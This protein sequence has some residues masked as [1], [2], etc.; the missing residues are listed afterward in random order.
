MNKLLLAV[1]LALLSVAAGAQP[2]SLVLTGHVIDS[3]S[4]EK[5]TAATVVIRE[6]GQQAFTDDNGD[7]VFTRL[8]A[9]NYMIEVRH[10]GC[11]TLHQPVRLTANAHIDLALPHMRHNLAGV[12]VAAQTTPAIAGFSQQLAGRSLEETRGLSLAQALSRINGVSM[13]STGST[14]AKPV[15]HG[16]HSNRILT[17]NNGVRQ[18]G[19]QWGNEHA[20]EID[21]YLADKLTVIKGVDELKYGS[22]AIGGVIL[23]DPR[24]LRR[25]PGWAGEWNTGYFSNYR[26]YVV[27]GIIEQQLENNPALAWRIQGT[28]KQN[29]NVATPGYR[30]NNTALKEL[31]FSA[32]A[33]WRK[34]HYHIQAYFSQFSTDLGLFTGSHTTSVTDLKTAIAQSKPNDVFLG[35]QTYAIQRP[36]QEVLHR[37]FKLSGAFTRNRHQFKATLAAQYNNRKEYDIV[38]DRQKTTP[39]V[40]LRILTLSEELAWEHPQTGNFKGTAGLSFMQQKNAYS[41]RYLIPNYFS[42][43]TGA[44][45]IE[46]WSRKKLGIEAG[47]RFD[48]KNI[49]TKRIQYNQSEI[50]HN[51]SFSTLAGSLNTHYAFTDNFKTNLN[52]SLSSRAPHVNELL[53]AGIHGGAGIY[54]IGDMNL[55]TEQSFNTSLGL[56]YTTPGKKFSTEVNIY[57]NHINNFIYTQPMANDSMVTITGTFPLFRYRQTNAILKGLDASVIWKLTKGFEW[58]SRLAL[59]RARNTQISDWLILMPSDRWSNKLTYDFNNKGWSSNS[60]IAAEWATVYKPRVPGPESGMQDYKAPPDAYSLMNIWVGTTIQAKHWPLT[61]MVGVQNLFNKAYREYMNSFRYYAN[62]MGRN[63]SIHLKIPFQNFYN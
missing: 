46:K 2:C 62:D 33:E 44:Y 16:L 30:L 42:Y 20:P 7:F 15:I 60:Y 3:D 41:G 35:E 45:W 5:L 19:Q 43:T 61:I 24:P 53:V 50:N 28:F 18:E 13:F 14:I 1:I 36:R 55:K 32:T 56:S 10:V 37:L 21:T 63:I 23:V 8:C 6:T 58:N 51:F 59:L 49:D 40:N 4:K 54:E 38:R 11:D 9:G 22:D 26:G 57:Y 27:S 29:G 47:A 12:V 25:L 31:N 34:E 17:I 52:V 48:Y 39:E